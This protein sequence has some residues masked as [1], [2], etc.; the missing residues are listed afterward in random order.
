MADIDP[1]HFCLKHWHRLWKPFL[2]SRKRHKNA[3]VWVPRTSLSSWTDEDHFDTF[4]L[5]YL[6]INWVFYPLAS[7]FLAF[8]IVDRHCSDTEYKQLS[9]VVMGR[10]SSPGPGSWKLMSHSADTRALSAVEGQHQQ[11]TP[12]V[13]KMRNSHE[14]KVSGDIKL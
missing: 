3:E 13:L 2:I 8:G 4:Y 5:V 9:R 12:A 7:I 10:S 14:A 11:H 1:I 6:L